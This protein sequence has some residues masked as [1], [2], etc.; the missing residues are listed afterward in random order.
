MKL[1]IINKILA[2]KY[3]R[4]LA[5]FAI[6]FSTVA[7]DNLIQQAALTKQNNV[8]QETAVNSNTKTTTVEQKS[9]E[10]TE[11]VANQEQSTEKT[12]TVSN[13]EQSTEKTETVANQQQK[14]EEKKVK[15]TSSKYINSLLPEATRIKEEYGIPLDITLAIAREESG[16]GDYIIGKGNHFGLRCASDDCI[17]LEKYGELISYETCPEV[18]ECFNIF[19][20]TII[21]LT[22]DKKITLR[23]LYRNGYAT[24]PH[25]VRRVG[26]IRREVRRTLSKA[27]IKYK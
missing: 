11:T 5:F 20:N 24:S 23:R 14:A 13:Q 6:L 1:S 26:R 10:E 12:E 2:P 3:F 21:D 27:G 25:W 17:T 16:N 7:C 8:E 9:T 18:S 22:G 19:A 4:N 15:K